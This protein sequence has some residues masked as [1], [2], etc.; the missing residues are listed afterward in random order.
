MEQILKIAKRVIFVT[1]IVILHV[2]AIFYIGENIVPRYIF[3]PTAGTEPVVDPTEPTKI[4]T[5][6]PVPSVIAPDLSPLPTPVSES[7]VTVDGPVDK[8]VIPVAG[9]KRNQLIDTY[10]DSRSEE[11][12]HN[13]IDIAAPPG[14]PVLAAADGEIVKFHDSVAG[15][16][17]IYQVSA[18]RKYVY[19]YAHLQRRA[20]GIVE[21]QSVKRGTV[22]G[23]VGDS[24]NAGAGNFHLHFSI[25][26]LTEPSRFFDAANI[27]PYPL[28]MEGIEVP[29]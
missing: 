16:I 2:F 24:G 8:L 9:V 12:V 17:T 23:Y 5:P 11:R 29:Q 7:F 21:K 3:S 27:N 18:D 26:I 10:N 19:Y 20:D 15:G 1:Y 4:P 25:G 22:I 13:A 14:T 28:L 6:L